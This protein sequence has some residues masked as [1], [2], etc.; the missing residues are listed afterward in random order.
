MRVFALFIAVAAVFEMYG[1][2]TA[3][4]GL[5]NLNVLHIYTVIEYSFL[6]YFLSSIV[7]KKRV[8]DLILISIPIYGVLALSYS[9]FISKLADFNGA[10]RAAECVLLSAFAL[11]WFYNLLDSDEHT[12]LKRYPEFWLNSG[13]TLY[14]MGNVFMFMLYSLL[15]NADYKEYWTLHSVL[16]IIANLFYF[17]GFICSTRKQA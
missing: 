14:F 11:Y 1:S 5:H 3:Y 13:I 6:A 17:V 16:N 15:I 10:G 12:S 7:E 4:L 2:V 8:K 9:I